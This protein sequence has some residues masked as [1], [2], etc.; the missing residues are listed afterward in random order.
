MKSAY[1][2]EFFE[3]CILDLYSSGYCD[4]IVSQ[5]GAS[6]NSSNEI[7]NNINIIIGCTMWKEWNLIVIAKQMMD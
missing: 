6:S 3:T 7:R 1:L 4:W 5:S 2:E